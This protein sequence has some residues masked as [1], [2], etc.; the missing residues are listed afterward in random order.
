M[1]WHILSIFQI[2]MRRL[3]PQ[4]SLNGYLTL[5]F[6][7]QTPH[8]FSVN[9]DCFKAALFLRRT[10]VC[11]SSMS[12]QPT[13]GPHHPKTGIG[14]SNILHPGRS[15]PMGNR[16]LSTQ[17]ASDWLPSFSSSFRQC[18]WGNF[19]EY[20]RFSKHV[21]SHTAQGRGVY[22]YV[23]VCVREMYMTQIQYFCYNY[24]NVFLLFQRLF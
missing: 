18:H 24:W 3:L 5:L 22:V 7:A 10:M 4:V 8:L 2:R 21:T 9:D 11:W 15:Q 19:G 6:L 23:C 20:K 16:T 12:I 14:K 17:T 13:L 1:V